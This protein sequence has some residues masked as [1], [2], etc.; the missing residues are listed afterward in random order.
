MRR[1]VLIVC[2]C[3]IAMMP[4]ARAQGPAPA[5]RVAAPAAAAAKLP[6]RRVVLYKNGVGYFEHVGRVRGSQSVTIDFNTAQ[7]NDVLQSL[8][9]LDLG[10]G[11]I[12]DVSF[13]SEAPFAQRL[14]ALTLPIGERTT[15]PELL[16]ALRGAR[17][18]VRTGDRVIAGRLLSIERRPRK[19]EAPRDEL[20]LVTDGGDIR[21]VELGPAVSVKLAER[22]SADQVGAYLGLLASNRSQNRRRLTI[23]TVG[24][25]ERDVMVSYISEVPVWKTTYRLV[26]PTG[27]T[28]VLQGWAVVDNTIGEDWNERRAVAGRRR[29][30]VVHPAAVAAALCAASDD[31]AIARQWL[32]PAA[33]SGDHDRRIGQRR[34][35]RHGPAGRRDSRRDRHRETGPAAAGRRSAMRRDATRSAGSRPARTG[36]SSRSAASSS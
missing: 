2:A 28:P 31:R 34:R 30:A 36:S 5:P 9:T 6:V 26:L 21:S 15:L 25:T 4:V 29:A 7:L 14:G 11:R 17:L 22:E 19:D 1:C 33:A 24:T 35:T 18:E 13:N 12:A 23:A 8:T 3:A 27:G 32:E 20:T 10:G 16:G